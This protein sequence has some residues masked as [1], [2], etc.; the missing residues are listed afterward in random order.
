MSAVKI[1]WQNTQQHGGGVEQ[2]GEGYSDQPEKLVCGATDPKGWCGL[3]PAFEEKVDTI[4]GWLFFPIGYLEQT[5]QS[6]WWD[7]C[8]TKK[9]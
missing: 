8:I 4:L 6:A 5:L 3:S 7:D 9:L 2:Y 1:H